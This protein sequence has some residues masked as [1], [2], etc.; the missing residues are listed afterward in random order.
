LDW[1]KWYS[2]YYVPPMGPP[3]GIARPVLVPLIQSIRF[4]RTVTVGRDGARE[5]S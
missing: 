1:V 5:S 4:D 2:P 3:H